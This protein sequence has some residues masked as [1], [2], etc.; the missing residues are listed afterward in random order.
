MIIDPDKEILHFKN[1]GE[2][3]K[4]AQ[5]VNVIDDE[6]CESHLL[7]IKCIKT[8]LFSLHVEENDSQNE[9]LSISHEEIEKKL[10][11][12]ANL[13]KDEKTDLINL[14]WKH[15]KAFEKKPGLVSD[16]E[17]D[18]EVEN[19]QPFFVKPYPI[20]L[21]YQDKVEQEIQTML[22]NGIIRKSKSNFINPVV[23][24]A[25]KDG[26]IRLCLDAGELNKRLQNN[27]ECPTGIEKIF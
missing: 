21:K 12:N 20:P 9:D 8:D 22:K 13:T 19:N 24:V 25:K 15:K 4:L 14:L 17:Y 2:T 1:N 11:D 26:S 6:N 23:I 27:P 5:P 7:T 16:F 10:E 3:I 18:L